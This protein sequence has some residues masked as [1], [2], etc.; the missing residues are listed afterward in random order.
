MKRILIVGDFLKGSGLTKFIMNIFPKITSEKLHFDVVNIGGNDDYLDEVRELGWQMYTITPANKNLIQHLRDWNALLKK[1]GSQY[2]AIHFNYS[3]LWNFVP[4]L[5]AKKYGIKY[6]I[7]HSHNTYFSNDPSSGLSK[8]LLLLL[9]MI[10]KIVVKYTCSGYFACSKQAA[11]WFYLNSLLKRDK[12]KIIKNGINAEKFAYNEKVRNQYRKEMNVEENLVI[13]HIG[14]FEKRKNQEFLINIFEKIHQKQQHSTLLLVGRGEMEDHIKSIVAE[15]GLNDSVK[16]L[17]LRKDVPELMQSF[18]IFVF[19]SL[20]EGLGIV[21]IEAQAAG[22]K[23]VASDIIP[24][25]AF[26]TDL[27]QRVSLKTLPDKWAD[28]ILNNVKAY[29]R[30]SRVNEI[31]D[32]GYSANSIS[33]Q[34]RIYYEFL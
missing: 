12:I 32:K 18:D 24:Q 27:A 31:F 23:C 26:V 1:I 5:L 21:L 17:G 25:E 34:L 2:D 8:V 19:P 20:F 15:K 11:E 14:V 6:I 33:Q 28:I 10:G 29:K 16:F 7:M 22:L 4:I 30:M 13:G 3:A 9:H